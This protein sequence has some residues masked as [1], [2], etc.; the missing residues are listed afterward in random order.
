MQE[1]PSSLREKGTATRLQGARRL[2]FLLIAA[3]A[4]LPACGSDADGPV[5][6][7]GSGGSDGGAGGAS[8]GGSGASGGSSAAGAAGDQTGGSS[9]STGSAGVAGSAGQAAGCDDGLTA[10][11]GSCVDL[12]IDAENCGACGNA[13]ATDETCCGGSCNPV[14]AG[15]APPLA[16]LDACGRLTYGRYANEDQN[17][18][19]NVL[20][21]FSFAGYERGGVAIPDVATV[22][23][24]S[25][26][27]GDDG[28]RI[29]AA[30]DEVASLP[31]DADGFRGA[32]LLEKGTYQVADTITIH[33]DGV[34]LRGEGQGSDGTVIR[35]TGT[36]QYVAIEIAGT[37]G[38]LDEVDGSRTRITTSYV[39]VGARSFEV[40]SAS[41]F[42]V[43]DDVAVLRTP[44]QS[45]I[46]DLG[47]DAYGWS[48]DSYTIAHE[49]RITAIQ[50][51]LVTVDIPIVDTIE[52][53]YGG[54][55][56]FKTDV[57]G[58]IG[59]CGVEDLRLESDYASDTD[60]DHGW[61]GVQLSRA[62]SSWVRRV[63]VRYFGY[64]AVHIDDESS[65]NTVQE[66]AMLDPKSE[67]T[68]GRR[69]PFNV[70]SGIGNLF[71]RCYAREGRHNFVTGSR[72]T[73]PN[74]WL[75]SL[76]ENNHADDGPH[77]RWATGL[78]FDNT[79]SEEL[80][81]QNR[82]DSGSGHGW[83][84]AQVMFWN[85]KASSIVCDAPKGAMNWA[86]GPVGDKTEG[87]WAPEEPFGWWESEGTV[88]EP[89]S[90]YLQQLSDRLGPDAVKAVTVPAQRSG[91]IW[92]ALRDWA[93]EGRLAD[94]L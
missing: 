76:A 50:G 70:S 4:L 94:Y 24:V 84:G 40:E 57:Q 18:E 1:I 68:G 31:L 22:R 90:L 52:D 63:T 51:N 7:G 86:V 45:W 69:Y 28:A 5:E 13:C 75:D 42:Q 15:S 71:Q 78:L 9:G 37:G 19:Q 55:A 35:A 32:V 79:R 53:A 27:P 39:G 83:A 49:R 72:V 17:N 62:T 6:A 41:G 16:A 66:V 23:V 10:C 93:G 65:F 67:I 81:V 33:T 25:P 14:V 43:G 80:R 21:D 54:G 48:P 91:R 88:V 60:E 2:A 82:Q 26:E 11:K 56:L 46:D 73:G 59:H 29:Q 89:R 92:S 61:I 8:T 85:A 77:H 58:R 44:N 30:I 87:Q 47:M 12:D 36:Q 74:V 38:G 3:Q 64:S 34:V 20:P